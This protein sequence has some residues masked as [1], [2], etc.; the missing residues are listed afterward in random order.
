MPGTQPVAPDP[1]DPSLVTYYEFEGNTNDALG[2][3]HATAAGGLS[4]AAGKLGQA[5]SLDE[6]DG[7]AINTFA[8]AEVWT[9]YSVSLWAKTDLFAQNNNSALFSTSINTS[10]GFQVNMDGTD[11]GNYIY[12]GSMDGMMGPTTSSWTHLGVSCDGVETKLYYN[13]VL[14]GTV[15]VADT[16]FTK[17]AVG[18][19]RAEDNWFGGEIDEVKVYDRALSSGEMAGLAELSQPYDQP[20]D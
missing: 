7:Q 8:Q 1:A 2:N 17:L 3:Y 10:S 5:V 11:P 14:S 20:F 13:G 6:I 12:H 16:D 15:N 19:N 4:Y 18:V 9:A